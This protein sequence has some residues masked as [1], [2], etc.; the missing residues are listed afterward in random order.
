MS[1]GEMTATRQKT[2]ALPHT[3]GFRFT[4]ATMSGCQLAALG[5]AHCLGSPWPAPA[6]GAAPA[7]PAPPPRQA[8]AACAAALVGPRPCPGPPAHRCAALAA[9]L[10]ACADS[11]QPAINATCACQLNKIASV[12]QLTDCFRQAAAYRCCQT[13][14]EGLSNCIDDPCS[15]TGLLWNP[16]AKRTG[17]LP[18][19][20]RRPSGAESTG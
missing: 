20:W 10:V 8:A 12:I 7:R 11:L 16:Y 9:Q 1:Y 3:A 4:R 19:H 14:A 17:T 6:C 13:M 5:T 15:Q 2:R 18:S